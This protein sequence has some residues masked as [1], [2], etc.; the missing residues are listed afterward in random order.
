MNGG[1]LSPGSIV[2]IVHRP[3]GD[4]SAEKARPALVVSSTVFNKGGLDVIVVALS[5]VIRQGDSR[6]IL[7]QDT[8]PSFSKTGLKVTSAI[9]C[10]ALFAYPKNQIHRKLGMAPE[11]IVREVRAILVK[12]LTDD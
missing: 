4:P 3:L 10:G 12:F 9:K 11:P 6:Q 1:N 8:D 5:S 2:L 7:I